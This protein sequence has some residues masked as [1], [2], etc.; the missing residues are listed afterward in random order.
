M[1]KVKVKVTHV[2][3]TIE[4]PY[5]STTERKTVEAHASVKEARKRKAPPLSALLRATRHY[6]RKRNRVSAAKANL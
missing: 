2:R 3:E 4:L 1:K 6:P 5:R